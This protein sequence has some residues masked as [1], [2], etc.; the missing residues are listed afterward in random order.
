MLLNFAYF[1]IKTTNTAFHVLKNHQKRGDKN[2]GEK[3]R[4][5]SKRSFFHR[6]A[7]F[8]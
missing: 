7:E 6:K 8:F 4:Q 1:N 2:R 5:T 3:K